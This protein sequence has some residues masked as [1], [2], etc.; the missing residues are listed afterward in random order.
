MWQ[1]LSELLP[2]IKE[3]F[4]S[5]R[6]GIVLHMAVAAVKHST[7]QKDLF[8]SLHESLQEVHAEL[9]DEGKFNFVTALLRHVATLAPPKRKGGKPKPGLSTSR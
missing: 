4:G 8:D 3:F 2:H 5:T 6:V 1:N 7:M 9:D